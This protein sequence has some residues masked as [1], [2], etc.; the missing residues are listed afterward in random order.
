MLVVFT[1]LNHNMKR[2]HF[3]SAFTLIELLVVIS[4]IG[5]LAAL[6]TVSFTSTQKQARDTKRESDIKQYQNAL[7]NYANS[8]NGLYPRYSTSIGISTLCSSLGISSCSEDPKNGTD[9]TFSYHY[10]SDGSNND[11]TANATK[12]VLWAKLENAASTYW[13]VCSTGVSG[14]ISSSTSFSGGECPSGLTQ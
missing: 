11:G 7:E 6:S 2:K 3:I 9:S 4:I 13:V 1:Q 14:K 8:N 5:V 12:Y 10:Q